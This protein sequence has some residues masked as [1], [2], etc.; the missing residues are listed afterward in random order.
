MMDAENKIEKLRHIDFLDQNRF[1]MAWMERFLPEN[2]Y[3]RDIIIVPSVMGILLFVV[4]KIG[5][6]FSPKFD[7]IFVGI[8]L[9]GQVATLGDLASRY[10][11]ANYKFM[12]AKNERNRK[13]GIK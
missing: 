9:V 12:C 5:A 2:K 8:A 10:A 6:V 1:C 11:N 13:N 4:L 3:L 7:L